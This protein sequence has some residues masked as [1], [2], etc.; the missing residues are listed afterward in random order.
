MAVSSVTRH[1]LALVV[2]GLLPASAPGWG[3]DCL[4]PPAGDAE[5]MAHFRPPDCPYC[6]GQRGL[7]FGTAAGD[8]VRA[9][10]P[11][12]V[13]FAGS[14]AGVNWVVTSGDGLRK[15]S[16]GFLRR[17]TVV[18]GEVVAV[19]AP[20]GYSSDRLYLGLRDGD[21]AIDPTPLLGVATV[22]TRL[23]PTDGSPPRVSPVEAIACVSSSDG[24]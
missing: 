5:V 14:V 22:S 10:A 1:L 12:T 7:E 9:A 3:V 19:G 15:V 24:R 23:V 4:F 20:L 21:R 16:Y 13:V 18:E 8:V 11:G 2:L 17:I 6:A